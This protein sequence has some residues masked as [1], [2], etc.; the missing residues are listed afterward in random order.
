ME[1]WQ[2]VN[3]SWI[4][5]RQGTDS[6]AEQSAMNG[7][8]LPYTGMPF[9]MN[10]F[11]PQTRV[12]NVRYFNP[13]D[14]T[15]FG[16]RLTHQP[17]PWMGD[18]A[19][20]VFNTLAVSEEELSLINTMKDNDEQ[21][22][23][24]N[25]S[26]Y[27]P[28]KA[29][30]RPHYLKY[31]KS[32]D[33]LQLELVPSA[34]GASI[35]VTPKID[36]TKI[37]LKDE[38][39]FTVTIAETG[40]LKLK[41]NKTTLS[42]FTNQLFGENRADFGMYFNL[43]FASE[44]EILNA[45]SFD[46]LEKRL[47]TYWIKISNPVKTYQ[48][49]EVNLSTSYISC[50]QATLN[51][52]HEQLV[53]KNW[54]T[55]LEMAEKEWL[56]YLTIIEIEDTDLE[57]LKT[58]YTCLYRTATFPQV[59]HEFDE[60]G[61]MIY[62]SP[63]SGEIRKG[64]FYTNN[65]FWDTFRT[66]YPLYSL[67]IPEQIGLFL[68]GVLNVAKEQQYLPKWLSPNERGLM[69]GNLVDGVI[70]DAVVKKLVSKEVAEELFQ[71]MLFTTET[72]S[73]NA[74]EGRDGQSDYEAYGYLP[75]EHKESVNK[76]L[77][78]AYSD[79]CIGRVAEAL[80]KEEEASKYFARSLRYRELYHAEHKQMVGKFKNGSFVDDFVAHRWGGH[81]TEGSAWQTSLG[82][83]HNIADLIALYGGDEEFVEH[84]NQ[85]VN[86]SPIYLVGDY[87]Q[88][89]H[90]ISELSS[91]QFGQLALS[92]QP[93]FHIPYLYVYAGFPNYSQYLVKQL[94]K[95]LFS[96]EYDGFVGDEDN[97]S[98]SSWFVLSSIGLYS[99]TPGSD[100]Y[101]LGMSIWE[102][103]TIRLKKD[104]HVVIESNNQEEYLNIVH[105]RTVDGQDYQMD[106]MTYEAIMKGPHIRQELGVMPSLKK[107]SEKLRPFSLSNHLLK[108]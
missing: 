14:H 43:E 57:G 106:Y 45:T 33:G 73:G 56:D 95:N 60:M 39:I 72:S 29:V 42:G 26:S 69:P 71:A 59:V 58:F 81:Y 104:K 2:L 35:K 96:T 84:L 18:F 105:A 94:L 7:N 17:S 99:V 52:Q 10:H 65:G 66:N 100:E 103:V 50:E 80:G 11:V 87:K 47:T 6:V 38:L 90:E 102:K 63:Y 9:G 3:I 30:Y 83:Y 77:D 34:R 24:L 68:E 97:G 91:V 92:N 41:D 101:V 51:S 22:L 48:E 16:I 27:R 76:T 54:L 108:K 8:S 78:Y 37:K 4:D 5:T 75:A 12:N 1:E 67:I 74:M 55:K 49:T 70:A 79:F 93:S 88:D 32:R 21:I 89:I 20:A 36:L 98:L 31:M 25:Q 15:I 61:A 23:Y 13:N 86:M 46:D 44:I 85:L 62:R 53:D 19:Y 28:E 107:K 82:V 64:A 40:W